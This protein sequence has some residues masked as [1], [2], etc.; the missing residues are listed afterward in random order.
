MLF[1]LIPVNGLEALFSIDA[2]NELGWPDLIGES[3]G[4]SILVLVTVQPV[5]KDCSKSPLLS[6]TE[7]SKYILSLLPANPF[8]EL[9]T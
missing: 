3:P 7:F 5:D 6:S 4:N 2:K 9:S 1:S 8:N